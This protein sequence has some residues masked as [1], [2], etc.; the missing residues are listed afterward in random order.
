M[1]T[2]FNDVIVSASLWPYLSASMKPVCCLVICSAMLSCSLLAEENAGSKVLAS[3]LSPDGR[4][5]VVIP[6]PLSE[7]DVP[8]RV[9]AMSDQKEV[10]QIIAPYEGQYV[11][12]RGI[13][14]RWSADS[15]TFLLA[16]PGKWS[17][18]LVVLG[19]LKEGKRDWQLDLREYALN[20]LLKL[21]REGSPKAF[22][23][24]QSNFV[25]YYEIQGGPGPLV[26]PIK[27]RTM[28][29]SDPSYSKLPEK[30]DAPVPKVLESVL[31]LEVDERG[32]V[33]DRSFRFINDL[34]SRD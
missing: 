18:S 10:T 22:A 1:G 27:F 16:F 33:H 26:F 29:T 21:T 32:H 4:L 2:Y 31:D 7:A 8:I 3:T 6:P 9:V 15:R 28:L 20:R 11:R 13:Q 34:K 30:V 5:G 23:S 17:L 25:V 14:C 19:H 12:G 24:K